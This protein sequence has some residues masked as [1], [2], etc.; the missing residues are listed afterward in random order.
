PLVA[1]GVVAPPGL[2]WV[3]IAAH[4][5]ILYAGALL[6]HT[7]L[8]E[9]RPEAEHLTEFYFWVALGGV[10]GGVFTATV[11]PSIFRTVLEYPLLVVA[12]PFFRVGKYERTSPA[13]PVL[14]AVAIFAVWLVFRRMDL[15]SNTEA[16]A[17]V[18]TGL[19]FALN[20][21]KKNVLRFAW[22]F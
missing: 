1:A 21:M 10:L 19:V 4:L 6:C 2:N 15:D 7:R 20:K 12:L 22:C 13:I 16:V 17:L 11:A 14:L 9:S 8:A 5:A 3:V 18:H